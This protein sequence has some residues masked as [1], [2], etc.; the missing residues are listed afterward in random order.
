MADNYLERRMEELRS[1]KI[2]ASVKPQRRP[3]GTAQAGKI[4]FGFK[5][6]RVLMIGDTSR[7]AESLITAFRKA[8]CPVAFLSS[9]SSDGDRL[10]HD[11]GIRFYPCPDFESQT[12]LRHFGNL[13][14]AWR[15]LD[16]M[17]SFSPQG[18]ETMNTLLPVWRE[19]NDSHPYPY[20]YGHRTLRIETDGA[21]SQDLT[22][23]NAAEIATLALTA[24][25]PTFS[26]HHARIHLS[27]DSLSLS[28]S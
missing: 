9:P 12:L 20:D 6:K 11:C 22:D 7:L 5:P 13:L 2:A 25:L 4:S 3:S 27:P 16:I 18:E 1:G 10:A 28:L 26:R 8:G 19:Y 14:K 21:A 17:I 15:G 24:S 23:E